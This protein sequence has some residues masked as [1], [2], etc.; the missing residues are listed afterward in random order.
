[1]KHERNGRVINYYCTDTGSRQGAYLPTQKFSA[2]PPAK[3]KQ[4]TCITQKISIY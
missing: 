2:T 4:R 3:K 1:M